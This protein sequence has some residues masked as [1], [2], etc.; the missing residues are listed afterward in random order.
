MKPG[1]RRILDELRSSQVLVLHPNDEDGRLLTDHLRR[2]GCSV[3]AMWPLPR[4]IPSRYDV[5]FV[6]VDDRPGEALAGLLAEHDP[7]VIAIMT[8]ETPTAMQ[9]ILDLNAHAVISKPLRP[10][11]ILAQFV[12]A[13]H[14][15]SLEGRLAG[16]VRKLEDTLRGRRT[17]ERATKVISAAR[18]IGED[19]AYRFLRDQATSRQISMTA[20]AE[21]IITAHEALTGLG[22]SIAVGTGK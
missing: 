16:K 12:L 2:L 7:A 22:L 11:G 20:V 13:R 19:E 15:R 8:Y 6:Q 17:V 21:S 5:V 1:P 10:F 9:S 14:R 3:Q 18:G 4:S